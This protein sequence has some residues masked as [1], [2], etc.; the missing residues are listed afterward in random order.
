MGPT[1]AAPKLS[2]RLIHLVREPSQEVEVFVRCSTIL[3]ARGKK[4]ELGATKGQQFQNDDK[5]RVGLHVGSS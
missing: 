2:A 4:S 5:V 1:S 3:Q